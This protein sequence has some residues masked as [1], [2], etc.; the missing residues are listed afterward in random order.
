MFIL[1]IKFLVIKIFIYLIEFSTHPQH[2]NLI[3]LI[4]VQIHVTS[5][6]SLEIDQHNVYIK[7][8]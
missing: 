2:I 1:K 4:L 8:N 5:K 6:L 3:N 7:S